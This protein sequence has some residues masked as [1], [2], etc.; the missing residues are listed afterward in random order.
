MVKTKSDVAVDRN[1]STTSTSRGVQEAKA[2][3]HRKAQ[4]EYYGRN[5]AIRE[6]RRL[7]VAATRERQKH[8]RRRWD[9]PKPSCRSSSPLLETE[10]LDDAAASPAAEDDSDFSFN[11]SQYTLDA[12]HAENQ[13]VESDRRP[14]REPDS[15]VF[16]SLGVGSHASWTS[17]ER[18]ASHTLITFA[19]VAVRPRGTTGQRAT[20]CRS[21][22]SGILEKARQLIELDK[23]EAKNGNALSCSSGD[24]GILEKARQL[25]ELDKQEAE[26]A[27][28]TIC[29]PRT[30]RSVHAESD[31]LSSLEALRDQA[32]ERRTGCTNSH[33]S[34]AQLPT[35]NFN[36]NREIRAASAQIDPHFL[37]PGIT[38]LTMKQWRDYQ[39]GGLVFSRSQAVQI[40]LATIN[41]G[42]LSAPTA[43]E[44]LRWSQAGDV[45]DDGKFW[46]DARVLQ[47]WRRGV[48]WDRDAVQKEF[49]LACRSSST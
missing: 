21:G 45:V 37:P 40:Y 16:G 22:D 27:R 47:A 25:S 19:A 49:D 28:G 18:Q 29:L 36:L 17:R 41:S 42:L 9:H 6:Q 11:F 24:S 2:A 46:Q 44:R 26:V 34:S 4:R 43:E 8:A 5:P 32:C 48:L 20:S 15:D 30:Q 1:N 14:P 13:E 39:E 3:S 35:S 10:T 12:P 7:Q 38:P 33:H 31:H 23:L